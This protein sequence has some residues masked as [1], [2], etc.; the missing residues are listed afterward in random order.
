MVELGLRKLVSEFHRHN[1]APVAPKGTPLMSAGTFV[2]P[3][4]LRASV[5]VIPFPVARGEVK[6][7]F[8]VFEVESEVEDVIIRNVDV[9]SQ[10]GTLRECCPCIPQKPPLRQ[11]QPA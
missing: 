6:L 1:A 7:S 10:A 9:R 3:A 2:V 8:E 5:D 4:P 11:F